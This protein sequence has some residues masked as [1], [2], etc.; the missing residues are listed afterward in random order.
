MTVI[1]DLHSPLSTSSLS[2]ESVQHAQIC[3]DEEHAA[4]M[5]Y[6]IDSRPRAIQLHLREPGSVESVTSRSRA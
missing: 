3:L 6:A 5:G 2:V 1:S 4:M